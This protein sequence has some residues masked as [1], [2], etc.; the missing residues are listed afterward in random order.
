[1]KR[2]STQELVKELQT[3]GSRNCEPIRQAA[4]RLGQLQ[5]AVD[6]AAEEPAWVKEKPSG[7]LA[8]LLKLASKKPACRKR[9]SLC[10]DCDEHNGCIRYRNHRMNMEN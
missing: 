1:M 7:V 8:L 9:F 2:I 3:C 5:E 6:M 10:L 4:E